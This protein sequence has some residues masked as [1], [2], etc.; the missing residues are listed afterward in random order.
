MTI[1]EPVIQIMLIYG[2]GVHAPAPDGT[3]LVEG[4]RFIHNQI[5]AHTQ[6]YRMYE[7]EFK[8]SQNGKHW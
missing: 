4:L 3:F 6:V 1:N 7:A 2:Y 8:S 5:L